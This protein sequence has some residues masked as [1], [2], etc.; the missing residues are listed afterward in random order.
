MTIGNGYSGC[1]PED[2]EKLTR[3]ELVD[4]V[5][6]MFNVGIY[7]HSSRCNWMGGFINPDDL[8]DAFRGR[9]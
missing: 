9:K 4:A 5:N 3:E 6:R 1:F 2:V 8:A 7:Q